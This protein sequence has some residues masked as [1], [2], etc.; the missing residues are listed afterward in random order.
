MQV[1]AKN[2]IL[3]NGLESELIQILIPDERINSS[4]SDRS[5]GIGLRL[6]KI[7]IW[8]SYTT[9]YSILFQHEIFG[10]GARA[11]EL[12]Y[13]DVSYRILLPYPFGRGGGYTYFDWGAGSSLDDR[14]LSNTLGGT[15]ATGVLADQ[16]RLGW[17]RTGK[18]ESYQAQLYLFARTD[19][20]RYIL[21]TNEEET[22]M[23]NDIQSYR[24][25]YNSM[26]VSDSIEHGPLRIEAM[27][28]RSLLILSD[29]FIWFSC[30]GLA[31]YVWTGD[32]KFQYPIFRVGRVN[33][34]PAVG[35]ELTPFGPEFQLEALFGIC[36]KVI[37]VKYRQGESPFSDILGTDIEGVN[38]VSYRG[39]ELDMGLF[40]W[41][42]P[43]LLQHT[44]EEPDRIKR[45]GSGESLT[46]TSPPLE[47]CLP[48]RF[49]LGVFRKAGGYLAGEILDAGITWRGGIGV[50]M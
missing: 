33:F 23:S 3:L 39:A 1:G 17:L 18:I 35:Y 2:L 8:N 28:K 31:S 12:G 40:F 32:R 48:V 21:S 37:L 22:D 13:K 47:A 19:L 34:I 45:F 15:E 14:F 50:S 30:W 27:K 7:A 25:A 6:L 10:H 5:S 20:M 49:S 46:I 26:R 43:T 11:R 42:Q 41:F 29:P 36:D 9:Y 4:F 44:G 24:I 16:I 38:L